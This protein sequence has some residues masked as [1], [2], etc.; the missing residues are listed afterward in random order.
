MTNKFLGKIISAEFGRVEE[1]PFLIG[2]QLVFKIDPYTVNDGGKYCVNI[3]KDCRWGDDSRVE[4]ITQYVEY[5]AQVLKDAN[6]NYVSELVNKPVEVTVE[7]NTFKDFRILTE[8][9]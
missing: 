9:I 2:L 6:C 1:R 5:V 4:I 7:G 3:S 8:V